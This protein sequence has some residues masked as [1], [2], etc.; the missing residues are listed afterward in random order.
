MEIWKQTFCGR[1]GRTVEDGHFDNLDFETGLGET[2]E[3]LWTL[4]EDTRLDIETT[5]VTAAVKEVRR[6]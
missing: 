1:S 5:A 2:A 6:C 4:T 3:D